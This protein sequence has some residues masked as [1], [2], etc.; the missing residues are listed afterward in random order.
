MKGVNTMKKLVSLILALVLVL[1]CAA[2][3]E[4]SVAVTSTEGIRN[5]YTVTMKL[6]P[7]ADLT[8]EPVATLE[9]LTDDN[10]EWE[11]E[12]ADELVAAFEDGKHW[13]AGEE[14]L[15][16]VGDIQYAWIVEGEADAIVVHVDAENEEIGLT[17]MNDFVWHYTVVREEGADAVIT[18]YTCPDVQWGWNPDF[19]ERFC[20]QEVVIDADTTEFTAAFFVPSTWPMD[21]SQSWYQW[22]SDARLKGAELVFEVTELGAEVDGAYVPELIN[23]VGEITLTIKKLVLE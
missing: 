11:G 22:A 2:M 10:C 17:V 14:W 8:A 16:T 9:I 1:S 20:D 21:N 19:I 13:E 5:V 3:A 15:V 23:K 4:W 7:A 18:A 12:I 6:V